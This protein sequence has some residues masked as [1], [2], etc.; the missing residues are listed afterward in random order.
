[1]DLGHLPLTSCTPILSGQLT[2]SISLAKGEC[3]KSLFNLRRSRCCRL[4]RHLLPQCQIQASLLEGW[5]Q[6]PPSQLYGPAAQM[7]SSPVCHDPS[8]GRPC[9]KDP[10]R[11]RNAAVEVQTDQ[12]KSMGGTRRRAY[13]WFLRIKLPSSTGPLRFL[14]LADTLGSYSA[15]RGSV[16]MEVHEAGPVA[17][18]EEWK[19]TA[20]YPI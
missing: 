2:W 17:R 15:I 3:R 18:K 1:M 16:Y 10:G 7:S 4:G 14:S 19:G 8:R 12:N 9:L 11:W 20:L 13:P 6:M 5:I